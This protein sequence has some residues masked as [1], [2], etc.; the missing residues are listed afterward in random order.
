MCLL[1][2]DRQSFSLVFVGLGLVELVEV[3][4]LQLVELYRV[5]DLETSAASLLI[6]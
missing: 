3:V 6:E 4:K 5:D 2:Y 1:V